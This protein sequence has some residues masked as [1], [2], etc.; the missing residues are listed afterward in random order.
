MANPPG[1]QRRMEVPSTSH[2]LLPAAVVS[3]PRL[4]LVE[5]RQETAVRAL[6]ALQE[7]SPPE[8][9]TIQMV[10]ALVAPDSIVVM[11]MVLPSENAAEVV[12]EGPVHMPD[13]LLE[14][15]VVGILHCSLSLAETV[16][17]YSL[18]SRDHWESL[19]RYCSS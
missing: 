11:N 5:L 3:V 17:R 15:S 14:A 1:C 7:S 19:S 9:S 8:A 16:V 13:G 4:E 6:A 10:V 18:G 12:G 2:V